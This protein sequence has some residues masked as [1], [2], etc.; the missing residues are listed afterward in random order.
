MSNRG[1]E[2]EEGEQGQYRQ[3]SEVTGVDE[4]VVVDAD[5]DPLHDFPGRDLGLELLLDLRAEGR[6]HACKPFAPGFRRL[7]GNVAH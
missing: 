6:A 2:N 7:G 1:G 4:A 3:I 5:R